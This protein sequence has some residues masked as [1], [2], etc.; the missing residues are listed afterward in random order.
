MV[1]APIPPVTELVIVMGSPFNHAG[2][3]LLHPFPWCCHGYFLLCYL[4]ASK[5][6]S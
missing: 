1:N 4:I 5:R 3:F 2:E 6:K